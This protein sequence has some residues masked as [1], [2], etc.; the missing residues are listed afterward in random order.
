MLANHILAQE[1]RASVTTDTLYQ[2]FLNFWNQ[3]VVAAMFESCGEPTH[4]GKEDLL[5]VKER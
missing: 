2:L 5:H 3:D 4:S 1:V